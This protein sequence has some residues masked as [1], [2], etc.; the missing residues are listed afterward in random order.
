MAPPEVVR[1]DHPFAQVADGAIAGAVGGVLS[2]QNSDGVAQM[3]RFIK[4]PEG[5]GF[6]P[7]QVLLA[8][9]APAAPPEGQ[10]SAGM[11]GAA[12]K[13][14]V[15]PAKKSAGDEKA[16]EQAKFEKLA[17]DKPDEYAKLVHPVLEKNTLAFQGDINRS[18]EAM[19]VPRALAEST[20]RVLSLG[21]WD[22]TGIS[23][24][25][26]WQKDVPA[27]SKVSVAMPIDEKGVI[28]VNRDDWKACFDDVQARKDQL[29]RKWGN[30]GEQAAS[31]CHVFSE[32]IKG[33][34]ALAGLQVRQAYSPHGSGHS[35]CEVKYPNGETMVYD[36]WAQQCG[37][38]K[39]L[40]SMREYYTD[41][42]AKY[43]PWFGR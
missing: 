21:L 28:Q 10:S 13:A 3:R 38:V 20:L 2:L 16:T 6:T 24:H 35:W 22:G 12:V 1:A 26:N 31:I 32:L 23:Q 4:P 15:P 25:K 18:N 37:R 11:K 5:S 30:C 9:L 17:K 34:P 8:Q 43:S 14:E 19:Q 40:K 7:D 42:N 29:N 27:R 41:P 33:D 36:P 39:D